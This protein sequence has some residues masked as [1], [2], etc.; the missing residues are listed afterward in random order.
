MEQIEIQPANDASRWGVNSRSAW[1]ALGVTAGLILLEWVFTYVQAALF[2]SFK[3]GS[4]SH[5]WTAMAFVPL[6][7][8]LE[9]LLMGAGPVTQTAWINWQR[10]R[11][12]TQDAPLASRAATLLAATSRD[13][14]G[15]SD[16][17]QTLV[18][19]TK[20]AAELTVSLRTGLVR[21]ALQMGLFGATLA[22][23]FPVAR[24][25]SV[26]V[27]APMVL[28]ALTTFFVSSWLLR[29]AGKGL[30]DAEHGIA[31]SDAFLR[32]SMSRMR[33]FARSIAML[34]GAAWEERALMSALGNANDASRAAAV[35][36]GRM[37]A[38]SG[39][40]GPTDLFALLVL[41]PVFFSGHM[42]LGQLVQVTS[43]HRAF[44]AGL[45]WFFA[46]QA[47]LARWTAA[48]GRIAA[49]RTAV[50]E[51][52]PKLIRTRS[53]A[54]STRHLELWRP[55]STWR[56]RV[57]DLTVWPGSA[58]V[59]EGPSGCGKSLTAAAL[60]GG[61]PWASGAISAPPEI[62]FVPQSPYFPVA[63]LGQ[64]L[65]YPLNAPDHP[66]A[67]MRQLLEGIGLSHLLVHG[68]V[69]RDW[70]A[71]LSGGEAARLALVRAL[72]KRPSILLLDEP[73]A[74]LDA[75][76]S[77][78]YWAMVN[79]HQEI[80]VLLITHAPHDL[81]RRRLGRIDLVGVTLA[82][83]SANLNAAVCNE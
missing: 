44:G 17:V 9:A 30:P 46:R 15:A 48:S 51:E 64:A 4:Y 26:V 47:E 27:P 5:F 45:H 78:R 32:R 79:K 69:P 59:L 53:D 52:F 19:D 60:A 8:L 42:S 35:I 16:L 31:A 40:L 12:M 29:L 13:S 7:L 24:L 65:A 1:L 18:E 70:T 50:R 63:S 57:P 76:S 75:A 68:D 72:L 28:F 38:L 6:L 73:G 14:A 61:W 56:L 54:L 77:Q 22:A 83:P 34:Q 10:T 49:F 71:T 41:S 58:V 67:E 74:N 81:R 3:E 2:D 21:S 39:L 23:V 62:Q 43:A 80:G 82:S 66:S 36:R 11:H 55:D 33:E 20:T 37:Q 25:G